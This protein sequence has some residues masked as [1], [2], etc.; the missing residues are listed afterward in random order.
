MSS[1]MPGMNDKITIKV[2]GESVV[3]QKR[4]INGNLKDIFQ[5]FRNENLDTK[6]CFA[7]FASLRPKHCVLASSC[8]THTVCVCPTHENMQLIALGK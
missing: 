4:L 5:K 8:G 1:K 7:K 2:A 6:I 3:F